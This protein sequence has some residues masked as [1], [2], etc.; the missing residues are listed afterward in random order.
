MIAA[1]LQQPGCTW[2]YLATEGEYIEALLKNVHGPA[3]AKHFQQLALVTKAEKRAHPV[4]RD[5]R[6]A[7]T[8]KD[9]K[10]FWTRAAYIEA[11][12]MGACGR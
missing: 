2:A 10:A 4:F 11:T 9:W 12:T 1:A 7:F 8:I 5:A 6:G 3:T